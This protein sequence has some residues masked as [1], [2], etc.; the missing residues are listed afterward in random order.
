MR[1]LVA[2]KLS[3]LSS[4]NICE[5]EGPVIY[6]RELGRV[7]HVKELL[8]AAGEACKKMQET[9][10]RDAELIAFEAA[11]Y[12][13]QQVW[14]EANQSFLELQKLQEHLLN[15]APVLLVYFAR[16]ALERLLI[17]LPPE[18]PTLS[19]VNLVIKEWNSATEAVLHI[20]PGDFPSVEKRLVDMPFCQLQVDE[21]LQAGDCRLVCSYA[22][23]YSS[24]K[25]NVHGF[26]SALNTLHPSISPAS[27]T[28]DGA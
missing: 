13:Q 24:F 28:K 23:F 1:S 7:R 10:E 14:I 16:Q 26:L 18:W 2:R 27:M 17:E 19:S 5:I 25:G 21:K 4:L 3:V 22:E 20:S 12:A 6:K 11:R 9:S 15:E 8:E